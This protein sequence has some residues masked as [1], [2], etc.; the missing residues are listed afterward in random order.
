MIETFKNYLPYQLKRSISEKLWLLGYPSAALRRRPDFIIVGA[1]KAGTTSLYSTLSQSKNIKLSFK[2]EVHFFDQ[3]YQ[4]GDRWYRAHFP[5]E[6]FSKGKQIGEATP[7]YIFCPFSAERLVQLLP[8]IKLILMLRDPVDRAVSH[9]FKQV[10]RGTEAREIREALFGSIERVKEIE[11]RMMSGDFSD[12]TEYYLTSYLQRGLYLEQIKRFRK[13]FSEDQLHIIEMKS[14]IACYDQEI[15]K[16]EQFLGT[17]LKDCSKSVT[18]NVGA[19][20]SQV[21]EQVLN[22]LRNFYRVPNQELFSYLG[23]SYDWK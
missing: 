7:S 14:Y 11:T 12:Q 18:R 13:H 22:E 4:R 8:G 5:L 3:N 20:K 21:D 9:Y 6:I 17:S 2:K 1:Q 15:L 16:L 23:V 10:R 19:N